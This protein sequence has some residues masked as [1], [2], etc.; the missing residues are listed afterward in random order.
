MTTKHL[1]ENIIDR[2][3][4][5]ALLGTPEH[6]GGLAWPVDPEAP[7]THEPEIAHGIKGNSAVAV[8]RLIPA[9]ADDK[10]L[11]I[12]AEFEQPYVRRD[13]RE[14][15]A[16]LRRHMRETAR[17]PDHSGIGDTIFIV[18]APAYSDIRFVLFEER[19]GRQPRIRSFGWSHDNIG[20]TVLTHNLDRLTWSRRDNWAPAWDVE[21][22]TE[23]FY[24]EFV[25]VFNAVKGATT[26]PNGAAAAHAYVQQ[27]LNRLLFISFIERMGWLIITDPTTGKPTSDY[28]HALWTRHNQDP[29]PAYRTGLAENRLSFNALLGLLFFQGLNKPDGITPRHNLYDLL[30]DVPYLNGGLFEEEKD[31]DVPGV[32]IDDAI[33]DLVF[34]RGGLFRRFNFTVTESTPLDQEVAVDPEMLGKIFERIIIAEERHQSGT[35]YTPRPIVEF[36]VNEALRGYLTERGL[37]AEKAA[38][39][40]DQD[41]VES[42]ALSFKPSE[43]QQALDWLFEVRA[44]DPACGS[45]AYL[46]MLLQRLFELVDRLEI[47]QNKTRNP[48]QQHLYDIKLRLL[49]RCVYGVDLSEVAVRIAKLRLWLSL[50]VENRG[51]K[52]DPLPHFDFLIMHGDSLASPIKTHLQ[53]ELWYPEAAVIEYV[54]FRQRYFH[55]GTTGKVGK[56]EVESRRAIIAEAF[57]DDLTASP[58]RRMSRK[59]FDWLVDFAEIFNPSLTNENS[60]RSG[61]FDIVLANPPYVSSGEL[62]R[63]VGEDYKKALVAAYKSTGSGNADLL[64]FF[65]ERAMQLLRPRGQLAFITSNKWLKATYGKKLCQH[66]VR[67]ARVRDLIDFRDLPVFQNVIAYPLVTLAEKRGAP[68]QGN[69]PPQ[70]VTRMTSVPSLAAPWPDMDELVTTIG[71]PLPP[72]SLGIDGHWHLETGEAAAQVAA[73]RTRG[74]PLGEYVK[75][76]INRGVLT[77]LNEV[78]FGDDGKVYGKKVPKGVNVVRKEGVFVINGAK[79]AELI[80]ED[81]R[82]AEI[83]KPLVTGKNIQRYVLEP[84]DRFLIFMRRGM[85]I[86]KYPA[87]KKHLVQYKLKLEPK[88][89]ALKKS[90]EWIG[91]KAGNYKWYEIQDEVA[92]W[93]EFQKPKITF[94]KIQVANRFAYEEAGLC[95]NDATFIITLKDFYLLGVL[96]AACFWREIEA[97]CP[98]VQNGRQLLWA[99]FKNAVIPNAS[100]GECKAIAELA[101]QIWKSKLE[102]PDVDVSHLQAKVDSLVDRLYTGNGVHNQSSNKVI[103]DVTPRIKSADEENGTA[104]SIFSADEVAPRPFEGGPVSAPDIVSEIERRRT[105]D[106]VSQEESLAKIRKVFADAGTR[107]GAERG[108]AMKTISQELGFGRLGSNIREELE[109]NL[110]TAVRRR[111]IERV[112]SD[113]TYRLATRSIGDYLLDPPDSYTDLR[114]FLCAAIGRTWTDEAEAI[115][116]TA[117]YLGFARTGEGISKV[118]SGAVKSAQIRGQV[119]FADGNIRAV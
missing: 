73:M 44:V 71:K 118:L 68:I 102:K 37:P 11:V 28:L 48:D 92:Y 58:L 104:F 87:I 14:L 115:R 84:T 74:I 110:R 30:G 96:N 54:K 62:K 100:E 25:E 72:G 35:Y 76:R 59:P 1:V 22:L 106:D 6:S 18:A 51:E 34:D 55:P 43:M 66:L 57:E 61:G 88:P 113:G 50:V 94:L 116:K 27:L 101:Q 21:G 17:F 117:R 114:R 39:L 8:H 79:R 103:S 5:V 77:G 36:M 40:I 75:G 80:A 19:E 90:D 81:P 49:Q 52:P 95:C 119:E 64:I 60:G 47:V 109:S 67:G 69:D 111:I 78:K 15:L 9:S 26:H 82:S 7:F 93:R 83:I 23:E 32:T 16:S 107:A 53:N 89:K 24:K 65:F 99:Q 108:L 38:M 41:Q 13:L 97:T 2:D 63:S 70:E 98:R 4:L 42:D 85:D 29:P 105:I 91:R 3:T 20:R 46:L 45:G 12:L 112:D 31:L 56:S 86:E 33:F 10:H